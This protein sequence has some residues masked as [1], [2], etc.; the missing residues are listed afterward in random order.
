MHVMRYY[1]TGEF[2]PTGRIKQKRDGRTP[3]GYVRRWYDGVSKFEHRHVVEQELG[4]PLRSYENV[5]HLNGVRDDNRL[6]NLEVWVTR[7]IKGQRPEDL[8]AWIV[9]EYPDLVQQAMTGQAPHLLPE[10]FPIESERI[11]T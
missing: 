11:S 7:Q 8:V 4:R 3:Q 6:E 2:G 1:K 5:H 9:A 10:P